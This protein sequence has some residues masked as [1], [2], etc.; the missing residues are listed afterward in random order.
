MVLV[1][2]NTYTGDTSSWPEPAIIQ[3]SGSIGKGTLYLTQA[4]RT[5]C[6]T[7]TGTSVALPNAIS[8]NGALTFMG[9][10]TYAGGSQTTTLTYDSV[11]YN[12]AVRIETPTGAGAT[13]MLVLGDGSTSGPTANTGTLGM[14]GST[15]GVSNAGSIDIGRLDSDNA[16]SATTS[17]TYASSQ[18]TGTAKL[19]FNLS[20]TKTIA[21]AL[22]FH[23]ATALEN[24]G[25]NITV[26]GAVTS[27]TNDAVSITNTGGALTFTNTLTL[28]S[29]GDTTITNNSTGNLTFS[30]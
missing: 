26:T 18:L 13:N 19:Q 16:G 21:N 20:G 25:G 2:N 3:G 5:R 27:G 24:L 8:G 6:S 11:N 28:G 17:G 15:N 22:N 14:T 29:G 7:K 12:G 4:P 9:D 1:G 10:T 23:A 30:R